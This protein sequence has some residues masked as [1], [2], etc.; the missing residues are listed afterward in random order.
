MGF[1]YSGVFHSK[2]ES[3]SFSLPLYR[4]LSAP[5]CLRPGPWCCWASQNLT[6]NIRQSDSEGMNAIPILFGHSSI[7]FLV[8]NELLPTFW[9]IFYSKEIQWNIMIAVC[10]IVSWLRPN[11][12]G[13][14]ADFVY[15]FI[16]YWLVRPPDTNCPMEIRHVSW[17]IGWTF[18]FNAISFVARFECLSCINAVNWRSE[19]TETNGLYLFEQPIFC[20]FYCEDR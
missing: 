15:C 17:F 11:G 10:K 16:R 19:Q 13:N 18:W 6:H 2:N 14:R 3:L 9:R 5:I 20:Y 1:A 12:Y 4:R 7:G 8:H